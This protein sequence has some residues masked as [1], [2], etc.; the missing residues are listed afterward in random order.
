MSPEV[1]THLPS[2]GKH[3]LGHLFTGG[4][5]R[6]ATVSGLLLL[7]VYVSSFNFRC[8]HYSSDSH[9]PRWQSLRSGIAT[10]RGPTNLSHVV[11]VIVGSLKTWRGRRAYLESWWQPNVSRG[12]LFLDG[13][14]KNWLLCPSTCPPLRINED[15][16]DWEIYPQIKY[17]LQVRIARSVVEAFWQGDRDVRWFV[18]ADDDSVLFV[19][20]I[21]EMLSKYD[22][23]KY[24]Y[25]GA[26]SETIFANAYLSFEM[27]FGGA[28]FALSYPLVAAMAKR[29]DGCVKRYPDLWSSDYLI[30]ICTVDLG[31]ALSPQKGFHQ[32]RKQF[33]S[34][35][36]LL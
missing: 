1:T 24:F 5:C 22:H 3:R 10:D 19:D 32:V 34:F 9:L 21:V 2:S 8:S 33:P 13:R 27:G 12:Y 15:I 36:F 31:V 18:V 29:L 30:Y 20:N 16:S 26:S 11:F 7:A 6:A 35:P 28:G 14:P 4:P 17:P 23:N 25:L